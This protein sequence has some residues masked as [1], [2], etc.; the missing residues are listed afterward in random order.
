MLANISQQYM[1]SNSLL[2]KTQESWKRMFFMLFIRSRQYIFSYVK[3][4]TKSRV[5][6]PEEKLRSTC[7]GK[8][9][10]CWSWLDPLAAHLHGGRLAFT[11]SMP[12]GACNLCTAGRQEQL[13]LFRAH[14][15]SCLHSVKIHGQAENKTSASQKVGFLFITS[16]NHH[17]FF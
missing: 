7:K 10:I 9:E 12:L 2:G 15:P 8:A 1:G 13:R 17:P 4:T 6:T 14:S 3:T 11:N 16:K 5:E